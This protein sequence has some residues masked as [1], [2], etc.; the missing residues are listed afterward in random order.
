LS[1]GIV[2]FEIAL[3]CGLLIAAGLMIKSVTQLK[4]IDFDFPTDVFTARVALM[5]GAYP[6]SIAREAM[7]RELLQRLQQIPE[8]ES[9]TL[10]T[11]LP[12]L[13]AG[14]PNVRIEGVEYD[15][16]GE[17]PFVRGNTI[18]PNYF[19]TFQISLREG[20]A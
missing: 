8:L 16:E 14:G 4:T 2:V 20:R 18:A 5:E 13:G 15:L 17:L 12:G 9:V 6:D 1:K 7:Q 11:A 10:L 3:S 19:E